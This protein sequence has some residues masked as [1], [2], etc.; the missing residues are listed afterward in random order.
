MRRGKVVGSLPDGFSSP[1]SR[2]ASARPNSWPGYQRLEHRRHPVQPRHRHRAARVQHDDRPRVGRRHRLD[3]LVLAARQRERAA[4]V[5]LRLPR[6]VEAHDHDRHI[7]FAGRVDR[8]VHR[9][10]VRRW[11]ETELHAGHGP[12]VAPAVLDLDLDRHADLEIEGRRG[13]AAP[14]RVEAVARIGRRVLLDH[15]RAVDRDLRLPGAHDPEA[16]RTGSGRR[17]SGPEPGREAGRVGDPLDG[18]EEPR[19][20]AC[21]SARPAPAR[22]VRSGV[23]YSSNQT[24]C[25]PS[26]DRVRARIDGREAGDVAAGF[27]ADRTVAEAGP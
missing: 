8:P 6:P 22:R 19:R 3:E 24:P 25:S 9:R 20:A 5:A 17:E 18:T 2:A 12:C 1:R 21:G 23:S 16:V 13:L 10:V 27:V 26:H 15:H 14:P 11:G 7:G 4:V